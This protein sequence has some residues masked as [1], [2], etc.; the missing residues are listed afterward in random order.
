MW[1]CVWVWVEDEFERE[2]F[3]VD[4][5]IESKNGFIASWAR[6]MG[7]EHD[8]A[9]GVSCCTVSQYCEE[10]GGGGAEGDSEFR[11]G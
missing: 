1:V 2:A 3:L 10:W 11:D 4:K 6:K 7:T 9:L 5:G 8:L